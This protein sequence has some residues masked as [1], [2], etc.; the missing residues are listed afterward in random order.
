MV[1]SSSWKGVASFMFAC[2]QSDRIARARLLLASAI[3]CLAWVCQSAGAETAYDF[4]AED[5][6]KLQA[7]SK[8]ALCRETGRNPD[9]G[10]VVDSAEG[11]RAILESYSQ[12][13]FLRMFPFLLTEADLASQSEKAT[14]TVAL[15]RTL[16]ACGETYLARTGGD[17]FDLTS[18][19]Q[20]QIKVAEDEI[21]KLRA[22]ALAIAESK[23]QS[24]E[25]LARCEAQQKSRISTPKP[26][27]V[28]ICV[29]AN[30]ALTF[31]STA[32]AREFLR[33]CDRN[34]STLEEFVVAGMISPGLGCKDAAAWASMTNRA[35]DFLSTKQQGGLD[36]V[37]PAAT[38]NNLAAYKHG[39]EL[40]GGISC[41]E[42]ESAMRELD[43]YLDRNTGEDVECGFVDTCVHFYEGRWSQKKC[44]CALDTLA[45]AKI[46]DAETIYKRDLI[47]QALKT[48]PFRML[49]TFENRCEIKTF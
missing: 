19:E 48:D 1:Y 8:E 3:F 41:R 40:S 38:F 33:T 29:P 6:L 21:D 22:P 10:A 30:S 46:A 17:G 2:H 35:Y 37:N 12:E 5:A 31:G 4:E 24:K 32:T 49:N 45:S 13:R 43:S 9:T 25:Y 34:L 42:S 20:Q 27:P 23:A 26:A 28:G 47:E 11:C 16:P 39:I 15:M 14:Y 7:E 36:I 18:C 44:E